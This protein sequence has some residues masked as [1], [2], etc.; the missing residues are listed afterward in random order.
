MVATS[1]LLV[2]SKYSLFPVNTILL[3]TDI[4]LFLDNG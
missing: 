3:Y 1:G 2:F 4:Y